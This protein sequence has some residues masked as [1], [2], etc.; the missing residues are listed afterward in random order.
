MLWNFNVSSFLILIN[1]YIITK[2]S[3]SAEE[4]A[5]GITVLGK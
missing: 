5:L 2:A 1:D 4:V 3:L